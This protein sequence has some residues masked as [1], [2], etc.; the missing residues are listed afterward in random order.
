MKVPPKEWSK[1]LFKDCSDEFFLI[2]EINHLYF[3]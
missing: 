2:D 3:G 1:D